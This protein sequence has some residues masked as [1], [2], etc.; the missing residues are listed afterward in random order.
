[1]TKTTTA[2]KPLIDRPRRFGRSTCF[3]CGSPLRTKNRGDEHVFP[4]WL[5]QRFNLWNLKLSLVNGTDIP[6][7][8]LTI[9]CCK[10]CNNE[11]LSKIESEVKSAAITGVKGFTKLHP[12]V[13]YLWL[14]KIYYGLLY[15]EHLL[16]SDRA[17]KSK[18]IIPR[19]SLEILGLHHLYLQAVRRTTEFPLGMPGSVFVFGT[20]Q[21]DK[22]EAQFD[23]LNLHPYLCLGIR[24]GSVGLVCVFQD[25]SIIK[26]FHDSLRAPYYRRNRLHPVQFREV[27]AQ[28]FYKAHLL[29]TPVAFDVLENPQKIQIVS[30]HSSDIEFDDWD[31]EE[32]CRLL[33][34]FRNQDIREFYAGS[35]GYASTLKDA[36]GRFPK[37]DPNKHVIFEIRK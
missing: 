20:L 26:A 16:C 36:N 30:R 5:L 22:A 35:S 3:L 4:K 17:T 19:E 8:Q 7:K 1:M 33:A 24:I 15:R 32:Y 2:Y 29:R 10:T 6:Y 23:F 31:M 28:I 13:T 11:H 14:A 34:H 37:L 9:P 21:P 25:S 18:P 12:I 27:A